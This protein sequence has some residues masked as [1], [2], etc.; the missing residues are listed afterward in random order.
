MRLIS[1][2]NLIG[3]KSIS[4]GNVRFQSISQHATVQQ[5]CA[6]VILSRPDP[7][8]RLSKGNQEHSYAR[9]NKTR[10]FILCGPFQLHE[11]TKGII[12]EITQTRRE[13]QSKQVA[14]AYNVSCA[15]EASLRPEHPNPCTLRSRAL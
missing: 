14:R 1:L 10:G 8:N 13:T 2:P 15:I 9:R 6:G 7:K 4:S 5:I 3:S 11:A 12:A